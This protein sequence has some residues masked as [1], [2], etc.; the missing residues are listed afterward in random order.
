MTANALTELVTQ[1]AEGRRAMTNDDV[2]ALIT[3]GH[4]RE[5]ILDALVAAAA[6]PKASRRVHRAL[7]VLRDTR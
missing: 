3:A 2:R 4:T 6:D 5:E 1:I 7:A